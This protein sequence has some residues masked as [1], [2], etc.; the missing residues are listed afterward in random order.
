[1]K[2]NHLFMLS[3]VI[4]LGLLLS[5]CG[6]LGPAAT[7]TTSPADLQAT[8][9]AMVRE[10]IQAAEAK[11][12]S[13]AAAMPTNT[14]AP[15]ETT[16]PPTNTPQ[17][18]AT[19]FIPAPTNTF[20]PATPKPTLT[21]TPAN[22]ACKL[23]STSP[24]AGTK[25]STNWDFDAVWKVQNVGL[26]TWEIGYVDL[27]YVSGTKMQTVADIFDVGTAVAPGGE[28]TLIVDMK[29]PSTAG[30]Y[31]ASWALTLDGAVICTLPV[32]IEA[33]AP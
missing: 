22:Y 24:T 27:K 30:K 4:T 33:V 14:T 19:I 11:L 13:T 20:V 23:V 28:L 32:D 15:T 3:A 9:D 16:V 17:P 6:L 8:V 7:P 10:T 26:K 29:T 31:T 2:R 12:T 21:S 25:Y 18:T 5:G 1:M